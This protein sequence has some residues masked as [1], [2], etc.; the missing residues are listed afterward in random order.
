MA[1]EE[2]LYFYTFNADTDFEPG[3]ALKEAALER[4]ISG[5]LAPQRPGTEAAEI[6]EFM[7]ACTIHMKAALL[8]HANTV[9][10]VM[11]YSE[12]NAKVTLMRE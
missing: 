10:L 1:H 12:L 8:G 6:R 9:S 11:W 3:G 5:N 7:R 2:A 4:E